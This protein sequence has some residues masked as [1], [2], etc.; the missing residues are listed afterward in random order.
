MASWEESIGPFEGDNGIIKVYWYMYMTEVGP[1]FEITIVY[2]DEDDPIWYLD[3]SYDAY[4]W[5]HYG[6]IEDIET[7][8]YYAWYNKADFPSIYSTDEFFDNPY[9]GPH[10]DKYGESY[11]AI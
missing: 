7:F 3:K 1:I 9:S 6:R 8:Y 5:M 10:N 2:K 11:K 4:R